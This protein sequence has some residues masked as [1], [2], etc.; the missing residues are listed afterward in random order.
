MDSEFL[1][2]IEEVAERDGRFDRAAYLF[3]YD[4]LQHTVEKLGRESLPKDQRHVSGRDLLMGISEYALAQFG[5]LTLQVFE[6]WGLHQTRDFG[7]IV[8]N[9]VE[10]NLMSKTEED[11]IEDFVGAYDFAEEFD[12]KKRRGQFRRQSTG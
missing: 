9:L 4:A 1:R 8:F 6:H 2:Q 5:P 3:L 7:E 10:S 11:C 12:W